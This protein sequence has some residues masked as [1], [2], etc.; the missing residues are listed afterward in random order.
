MAASA[1]A[2]RNFDSRDWNAVDIMTSKELK[3]FNG[4]HGAYKIWANRVKDHFK[5]KNKCWGYLFSEIPAQKSPIS[6]THLVTR[7]FTVDDCTFEVD[8]S[9]ASNALWTFIGEHVIDTVYNNRGLL[10]GG[11]ENGLELW[12]ALFLKHEGGADQVELGGMGSLHKF[13]VCE[14]V[15]DLQ[16]YV[17]KWTEMKDSFG[18]GISEPHLKSMFINILP[19]TVQKEVRENK[20]LLTLQSCID[21]VLTDL[22]RI[23]DVNLSKLHMD[24]LKQSL[25][26]SQRI[27]P[28]LDVDERQALAE[29]AS[30]AS[31]APNPD[32]H[33]HSAISALSERMESLVAAISGGGGARPNSKTQPPRRG[34]SDFAKFGDK[35]LHCGSDKHRARECP[36]KKALLDKNGGKFPEGYKSAFDKWKEK[37]PK[38]T[39]PVVGALLDEGDTSSEFSET[40]DLPVWC[41]SQCAVTAT[42]EHPNPFAPIAE[43][44]EDDDEEKVVQ[45]LKHISSKIAVGPKMSQKQKRSLSTPILDKKNIAHLA[46]LVRTGEMGL[47]DLNLDSNTDYEE[48]WALVDSGAAKSCAKRKGHFLNTE[49]HLRPS[50]V[51]MATASGE[52]LPS[53]GCFDLHALTAEGNQLSQTF[54]DADVDMP[55]MSVGE[56]STNG[57][58][59]TNVLFGERDGYIVDIK[60]GATSKFYRRRGVYFIKIYV[61]RDRLAN[62]G[63]PRPGAP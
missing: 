36:V 59:G 11:G 32:S 51:R 45:A 30:E 52:E 58:L 60:T 25:S 6:K 20:E 43:D 39:K 53:R 37:Q 62:V 34:M 7:S 31:A 2:N 54:E 35:C 47:P 27:S 57:E 17:G 21:H 19:P 1:G 38:R 63:F 8:L 46:K 26:S 23:N 15:D 55:I 49:T 14:K 42:V 50:N 12:R 41:L 48:A 10:C 13:P 22:G 56:I 3:P 24:R 61:L 18:Q 40:S 5:K 16:L 29:A 28:V 9:W 33:F 4:T 44:D